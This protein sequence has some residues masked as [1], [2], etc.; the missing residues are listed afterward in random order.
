M[1]K[2]G[3]NKKYVALLIE[4]SEKYRKLDVIN[5]KTVEVEESVDRVKNDDSF[6]EPEAW[7]YHLGARIQRPAL[8]QLL[9]IEK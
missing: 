6:K 5:S 4:T 9:Q 3:I 2:K 1:T 7:S 8:A